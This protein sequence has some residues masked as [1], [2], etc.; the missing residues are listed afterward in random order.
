MSGGTAPA[1][2]EHFIF[3]SFLRPQQVMAGKMANFI[4]FYIA[5]H[6]SGYCQRLCS[7]L[8]AVPRVQVFPLFKDIAQSVSWD[9]VIPIYFVVSRGP[10]GD[11]LETYIAGWYRPADLQQPS[12]IGFGPFSTTITASHAARGC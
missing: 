10:T 2:L 9:T 11:L 4:L 7:G 12:R 5:S 6:S 3:L 8:Y 1:S